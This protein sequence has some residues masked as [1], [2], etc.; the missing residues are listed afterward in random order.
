[1]EAGFPLG[2]AP[3]VLASLKVFE[4]GASLETILHETASL[5]SRY[6]LPWSL[7]ADITQAYDLVTAAR[8]HA[9]NVRGLQERQAVQTESFTALSR[10]FS[11]GRMILP[12]SEHERRSVD[13]TD[14]CQGCPRSRECPVVYLCR[15]LL[16]LRM[17][18]NRTLDGARFEAARGHDDAAH[19]TA[20][21][22]WGLG[23]RWERGTTMTDEEV[24]TREEI[25]DKRDSGQVLDCRPGAEKLNERLALRRVRRL[26]HLPTK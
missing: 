14:S 24:Q 15:E 13:G 3:I 26:A 10:Y 9:V 17:I 12:C 8:G 11:E 22:A 1:V 6:R 20:L 19:A 2:T 18:A 4:R 21:A 16:A 25:A 5:R 7:T 23:D